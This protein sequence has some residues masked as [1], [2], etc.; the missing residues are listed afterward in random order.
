MIRKKGQNRNRPIPG[1]E[2]EYTGDVGYEKAVHHDHFHITHDL[3]VKNNIDTGYEWV[4]VGAARW[5]LIPKESA[6][7]AAEAGGK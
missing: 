6:M 5:K 7:S 2:D 3:N 1:F 4:Q